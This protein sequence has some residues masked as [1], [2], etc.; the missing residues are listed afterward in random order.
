MITLSVRLQY[1][2]NTANI[3]VQGRYFSYVLLLIFLAEYNEGENF[4]ATNAFNT[5]EAA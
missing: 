5:A 4:F 2:P 3:Q 1:Y